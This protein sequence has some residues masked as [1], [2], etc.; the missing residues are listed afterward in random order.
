M[1]LLGSGERL[2][3]KARR[4]PVGDPIPPLPSV[5]IWLDDSDYQAMVEQADRAGISVRDWVRR[6]IIERTEQ[7]HN[8]RSSKRRRL[9]RFKRASRWHAVRSLCHFTANLA[10]KQLRHEAAAMPVCRRSLTV[11]DRKKSTERDVGNQQ[12]LPRC[13]SKD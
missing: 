9:M 3:K 12:N 4:I 11:R 7:R 13:Q 2:V 1:R 5:S 6:E 10:F 8:T